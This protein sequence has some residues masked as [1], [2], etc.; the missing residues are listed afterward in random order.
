MASRL[1]KA[2]GAMS[3]P[4]RRSEFFSPWALG[5]VVLLVL[6]DHFFKAWFHNPLTGKLSDFA[7]CFFLPLF[8]DAVL[9]RTGRLSATARITLGVALTLALFVP[10]KT[11]VVAADVVARALEVLAH[12]F[13]GGA[14]HVVADPTDLLAVPMVGL[15]AWFALRR[16]PAPEP[17]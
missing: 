12:P 1:H 8:V 17:T 4:P 16:S 11:S 15:A 14:M 3:T 5:A 9:E 7:G 6:N 10:I 2:T 13:G